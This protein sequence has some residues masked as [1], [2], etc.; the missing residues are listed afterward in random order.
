M[1]GGKRKKEEFLFWKERKKGKERE[2][3][4]ERVERVEKE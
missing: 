2:E 4:E 1:E 3:R